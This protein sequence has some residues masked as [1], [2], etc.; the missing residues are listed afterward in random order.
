VRKGLGERNAR[1]KGD[2]GNFR[3]NS[4][5][6]RRNGSRIRYRAKMVLVVIVAFPAHGTTNEFSCGLRLE[7]AMR[8]IAEN[9]MRMECSSL[10]S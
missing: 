10:F 8:K 7:E 4:Q 3:S 1:V 2:L 9:A 5:P 6:E